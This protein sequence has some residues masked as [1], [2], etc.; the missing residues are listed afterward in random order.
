MD[1]ND[2]FLELDLRSMTWT[3]S[4]I[5]KNEVRPQG[6][7]DHSFFM[8]REGQILYIFGGY[9]SGGKSNDLWKYDLS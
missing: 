5:D 4:E 1:S 7:D 2:S 6:R 8:D 3:K 9:V